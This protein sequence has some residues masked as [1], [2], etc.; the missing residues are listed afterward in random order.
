MNDTLKS[1]LL[2]VLPSEGH[3]YVP[4]PLDKEPD[5]A[6]LAVGV[7]KFMLKTVAD[8]MCFCAGFNVKLVSNYFDAYKK[9]LCIII[10]FSIV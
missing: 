9:A 3:Q 5:E 8:V 6:D 1:L 10:F 2:T 4:F 7:D